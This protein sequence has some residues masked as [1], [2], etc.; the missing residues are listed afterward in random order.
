MRTQRFCETTFNYLRIFFYR[1]QLCAHHKCIDS[2]IISIKLDDDR[3]HMMTNR[4]RS[5]TALHDTTGRVCRRVVCCARVWRQSINCVPA[6]FIFSACLGLPVGRGG[7]CCCCC[8]R[9]CAR[10]ETAKRLRCAAISHSA[11]R[12]LFSTKLCAETTKPFHSM[13]INLHA[14]TV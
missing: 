14:R 9:K 3:R 11:R 8:H 5:T 7:G 10:R 12:K 4:T 13:K 1:T 6:R 2:H